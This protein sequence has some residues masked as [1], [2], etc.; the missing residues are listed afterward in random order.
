MSSLIGKYLHYCRGRWARV[1]LG[2]TVVFFDLLKKSETFN[3]NVSM[4]IYPHTS[5]STKV[6]FSLIGSRCYEFQSKLCF[7]YPKVVYKI[8]FRCRFCPR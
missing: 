2:I 7:C 3:F 8:A 1:E 4:V 6:C 5:R